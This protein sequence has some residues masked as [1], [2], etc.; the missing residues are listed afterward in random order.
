[1]KVIRK[2]QKNIVQVNDLAQ[3]QVGQIVSWNGDNMYV[4]MVVVR[5]DNN[6]IAV[7]VNSHWSDL[8]SLSNHEKCQVEILPKGTL[9]EI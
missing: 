8:K 6:L 1:M 2:E 9:L 4:G 3:G 7:G 5:A